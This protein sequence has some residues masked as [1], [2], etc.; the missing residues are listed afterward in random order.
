M[1]CPWDKDRPLLTCPSPS[2]TGLGQA[3][4]VPLGQAH[5]APICLSH[6]DRLC[7][8][9]WLLPVGQVWYRHLSFLIKNQRGPNRIPEIP[10]QTSVSNWSKIETKNR[11]SSF[12]TQL[13]QN[14]LPKGQRDQA[15]KGRWEKVSPCDSPESFSLVATA[16]GITGNTTLTLTRG[17]SRWV[18][19]KSMHHLHLCQKLGMTNWVQT[20]SKL[21]RHTSF[22]RPV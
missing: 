4:P 18:I 14:M 8:S 5:P 12:S 19:R 7:L 15:N 17:A 1:T 16:T 13:T 21:S 2:G 6:W 3:Q 10:Y 22:A 20:R 9:Q 11:F